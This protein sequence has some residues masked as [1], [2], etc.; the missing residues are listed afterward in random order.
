MFGGRKKIS[1]SQEKCWFPKWNYK[2]EGTPGRKKGNTKEANY[3]SRPTQ[4]D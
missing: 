1:G 3:N 2:I 4:T